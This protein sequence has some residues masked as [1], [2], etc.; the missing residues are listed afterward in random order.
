MIIGYL[1]K[2]LPSITRSHW[3]GLE[4]TK[5]SQKRES[6]DCFLYLELES[7]FQHSIVDTVDF[8]SHR[9]QR[10]NGARS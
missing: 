8:S 5:F 1:I 9:L 6:V 4:C 3:A 7:F 10:L 2:R